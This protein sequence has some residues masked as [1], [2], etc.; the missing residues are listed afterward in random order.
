MICNYCELIHS[1][2]TQYP[3]REATRDLDSD[4]PRCDWHW[5]Y[6]CDVC[7][8]PR[9][10]NGITWCESTGKFICLT[11]GEYNRIQD[12]A[13]WGWQSYYVVGCP[14]CHESHPTLDRLEF[15]T[16]HPWQ[17]HAELRHHRAHLS[18][19]QDYAGAVIST[20][21][22]R[23]RV[24]SDEV[25][26]KAWDSGAS[27]WWGRYDEFGDTNRRY[28]IDPAMRRILGP[29]EAIRI[30]DAGCGNGYL[31]RLLARQGARMVGVDVSKAAI[32]MAEAAESNAPQGI[33]YH[34]GSLCDLSMFENDTFDAIVSNIVLDDL[35]DLN[36]AIAELARVLKPGGKFIF[37]ILHPCFSSPPVHGWV[38]VPLDS[39]RAEDWRY[40]KVDRYYE[41]NIET[42][43]WGDLPPLYSFHRPLS[44]YMQTLIEN[45]FILTDFEEPVPSIEDIGQHY[46]QL[47]DCIRIAWFLIIG[48]VNNK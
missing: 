27:K 17:R 39:D 29:V 25:V 5:R 46:R 11:C 30:L 34:V 19:E 18:A 20:F 9:H 6:V 42:W 28:I 21:L 35:Q 32:R 8:K 48:A 3:L 14:F 31:C 4:V 45:D 7:G 43:Q 47:H 33:T 2:D 38:K 16:A 24:I 15:Q 37:S 36:A 26:G 13:F 23:D 44:I 1:T 10:F 40:W 12:G 41:Q 22:P